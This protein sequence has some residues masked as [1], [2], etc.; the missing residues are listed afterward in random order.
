MKID[1]RLGTNDDFKA[2]C[3]K[4]HDHDVKVMLDGVFNHVGRGFWAFKDVREKKWDSPYNDWFCIN[5][6]GN[7]GYNDGFWYEGWEG[8]Y[9]LV[10]LNLQNPAVAD[11]L[12]SCVKMWIEEF[13]IDGLRLDVAYS[14]DHNFMKRLRSYCEEL[15][16]GFAL[17]GEVLF[18]D[19][20]LIVNDE[21]LHSC[22]NYE[23]YKGIYSSFNS[24]NMFEIAHSLN[25]QYGT[26]QWCIYRGKHL[27]TFVDNHDVSRLATILTD[28]KHIPLAYGL[29]FG[30]PGIPC[31][32]YGSEWGE[33]GAK[34]PDND[35]ALRPC[36]EEPKPN[37]LTEL[38]R[39]MISARRASDALCNGSY[40][41]VVLTNHQLIFERR[42]DSDRMLI[43]INAS[44]SEYTADH[45]EL[46]GTFE[47]VLSY[48][49]GTEA[50]GI[51]CDG[52]AAIPASRDSD[53]SGEGGAP[54]T[55][56][57]SGTVDEAAAEA[58]TLQGQI[59]MPPYS[60]QYFHQL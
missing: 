28:K 9:E 5:F 16:P 21:M 36:F 23:C 24:M 45:Q 8:H 17:I 22:T 32:Y 26:E 19:Y 43:A 46:Q 44:D 52:A 59:V 42:T 11:H 38:I 47:K 50:G 60:V 12:L 27:M 55:E 40:R 33:E 14:L 51:F 10:K 49:R 4:L 53:A 18:G 25:R 57:D 29:L 20:N 54:A 56:T 15:K 13:G 58:V 6:D 39:E 48:P 41:S 34:A 37:G 1:C 3:K 7:S 30:M 31:I 35:Y 2:V